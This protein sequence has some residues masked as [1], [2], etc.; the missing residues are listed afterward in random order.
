MLVYED[1]L[2][3]SEAGRDVDFSK[4]K[5]IL[6]RKFQ[7]NILKPF[8]CLLSDFL[9]TASAEAIEIA[10]SKTRSRSPSPKKKAKVSNPTEGRGCDSISASEFTLTLPSSQSD[11]TS[12]NAPATPIGNK[13]VFSNEST[14]SYG[15][16][17][18][19]T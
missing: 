18:T 2:N 14:E 6:A 3:A 16:I 9:R 15:L 5:K 8:F 4:G 19:E 12:D 17:S 1:M 11:F 13:R 7:G 10:R